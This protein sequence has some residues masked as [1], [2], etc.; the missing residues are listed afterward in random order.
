MKWNVTWQPAAQDV[1]AELWNQSH[2]RSAI[3][4]AS[5]Q[6]DRRLQRDP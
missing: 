2:D 3:A 5:D 6:I 4:A 1:L